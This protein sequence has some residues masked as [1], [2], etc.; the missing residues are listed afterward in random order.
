LA[1]ASLRKLEQLNTRANAELAAAEKRL[2]AGTDQAK[3]DQTKARAADA[4]QKAADKVAELRTQL[5]TA[6]ANAKSKLDAAAATIEVP[7]MIRNPD[8]PIGT[9]VFTAVGRTDAGPALDCGHDRHRR[10]RQGRARPHHHPAG[11]A[12]SHCANR[13]AAILAHHLG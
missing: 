4:K 3:A 6:K 13:R 10:R 12:R 9:H 1:T 2:A 7:I 8:K 11:C 5:D